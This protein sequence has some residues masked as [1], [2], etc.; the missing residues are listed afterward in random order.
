MHH[1]DF[2]LSPVMLYA[3]IAG[4]ALPLYL[5]I[6]VRLPIVAER[7]AVQ[8]LI[9]I[10]VMIAFWGGAFLLWPGAG[11]ATF[12]DIVAALMIL[13]GLGLFYLEAWALLSRGYTLGLLLTLLK[14]DRP[15]TEGELAQRYRGGE[16]LSWIMQHRLSGLI[17]AGLI[18][19]QEGVL[20]LTAFPGVMVAW[21]YKISIGAIGLQR[22]G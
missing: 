19:N 5:L 11:K 3:L 16:G 22:T 4:T 9:G 6:I 2:S 12:G 13:C 20:T 21:L 10:L 1:L 18:K 14:A 7:N 8:F 17:A 15:L